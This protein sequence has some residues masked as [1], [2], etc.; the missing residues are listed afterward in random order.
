MKPDP[1][2][3]M[4]WFF[5]YAGTISEFV[6]KPAEAEIHPACRELLGD[7]A[8]IP[9]HQVAV[10][11]SRHLDDLMVRVDIPG[12]FLGGGSG[13]EWRS[14]EGERFLADP[15][16]A[17]RLGRYRQVIIPNLR[18]MEQIP[19]IEL[20]DKKW[21]IAVHVLRVSAVGRNLADTYLRR[22]RDRRILHFFKG[23]EAYEIPFLPGMSKVIGV[24]RIAEILSSNRDHTGMV[25]AGDDE[26]DAT[27]MEWIVQQG[28]MSFSVGEKAIIPAARHVRSP[29]MLAAEIRLLFK[30]HKNDGRSSAESR[31]RE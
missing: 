10:L 12:L 3:P 18:A 13:M 4:L 23:R 30:I 25:Y 21:S 16:A 9:L 29:E 6:S 19:G 11:S 5:D 26:N 28:G 2:R 14:P 8:D 31:P 22:L 20:E 17:A 24:K 1:G 7:L 15:N 27:A